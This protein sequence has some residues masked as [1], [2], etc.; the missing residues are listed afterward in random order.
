MCS[1]RPISLES[2]EMSFEIHTLLVYELSYYVHTP[3]RNAIPI[4]WYK[5]AVTNESNTISLCITRYKALSLP[6]C[7]QDICI[8]Y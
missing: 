3:T 4:T 8:F 2:L 7:T 5:R 6:V 1:N